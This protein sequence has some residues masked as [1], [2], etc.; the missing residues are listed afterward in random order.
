V[1][2]K[3]KLFKEAIILPNKDLV[4]SFIDN[5]SPGMRLEDIKK[6]GDEYGIEVVSYDNFYK[7]LPEG[8][9]K[10]APNKFE[11]RLFALLNPVTKKPRVVLSDDR[12]RIGMPEIDFIR[13]MLEHETIHGKQIE[14]R[15]NYER[16]GLPDPKNSRSYFSDSDEIM[17][18]SQSITDMALNDRT[19]P[20]NFTMK[21]VFNRLKF[22]P[23]YLKAKGSVD[24]ATFKKYKKYIFL[25]LKQ[26]FGK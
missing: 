1:I 17:A 21:D 15:P 13:H 14:K 3:F 20:R 23:L 8:D 6:I 25:Y 22:N 7:D 26:H 24:D 16:S 10:T 12:S 18:M 19:L 11:A 4:K 5:L 2:L 9:K